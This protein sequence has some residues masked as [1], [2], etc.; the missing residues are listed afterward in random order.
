MHIVFVDP[1]DKHPNP[2]VYGTPQSHP[3]EVI[4]EQLKQ[5]PGEWALCLR[6]VVVPPSQITRGRIK[7]F[8]P[9]GA[10]LARTVQTH[11]RDERGRPLV[12]LY[13]KYLGNTAD[14]SHLERNH[15]D[16]G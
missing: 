2:A 4:A 7:A 11:T 14:A 6:E 8:Q 5:R 3:W 1:P 13:I 9:E 12:D 15:N 10:F 16:H